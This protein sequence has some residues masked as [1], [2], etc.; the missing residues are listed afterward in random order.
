MRV[1]HQLPAGHG[2]VLTEPPYAEW[3]AIAQANAAAAAAWTVPVAG[4]PL[5][6]LRA[7]ARRE[8]HDLAI[9]YSAELGLAVT[10]SDAAV[11]LVVMTGHQPELVHPG[12]WIKDFLLDRLAAEAGARAVD[13]VVDSDG[14]DTVTL[15]VPCFRPG[16]ARCSALLAF[17]AVGGCYA[18]APPPDAATLASFR[19]AGLDALRTLPA[20]SLG[21]HFERYCECLEAASAAAPELA[22]AL[23][24]AR[25]RYEAPAGTT[26]LE[27]PVTRQAR[28]RAFRHL[29]AALACDASRFAAVYNAEL[30]EF[31]ERAGLRSAAQ[32]FPDL[33]IDGGR[34]ELPLW[35]ITDAERHA[36]FVDTGRGTLEVDE[37]G[38]VSLGSTPED[39]V[40]VLEAADAP[41]APRALTLTLFERLF[42]ADLFIHGVGG[43]RYDQV[44]DGVIRTYFGIE[45][46]RFVIASMTLHL[47]L[48]GH[49][50]TDEEVAQTEQRLHTLKH[51][52]D[53]LLGEV[54]FDTA[55]EREL[56]TALTREKRELVAAISADGADRK[57]LGLRIRAVNAELARLL[58]PLA[59]ETAAQL[60]LLRTQR[61][62]AAVLSDRTYPFCLWDPLEVADKVR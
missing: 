55:E 53:Q 45:P 57:T 58:K 44:T 37:V 38:S 31:R 23:T 14:F 3:V 61:E 24:G 35:W 42:V 36:V 25:R 13:V 48:G 11:D 47:P 29:V 20:P 17:G 52:P 22:T 12:V 60:D 30:A 2:E 9:A 59:E 39:A 50:V 46:P 8:A 62:T 49:V 18:T 16:A 40:A 43:G 1:R 33:R 5:R 34:V 54:I 26:Y 56:A 32:P 15:T 51:N 10:D 41:L 6:G 27:L 28:T 4:V 19:A 7:L 21:R